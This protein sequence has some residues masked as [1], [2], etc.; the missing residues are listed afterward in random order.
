MSVGKMSFGQFFQPKTWKLLFL[1]LPLI[2]FWQ[3]KLN[4]FVHYFKTK[5]LIVS[6]TVYIL[7]KCKGSWCQRL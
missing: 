7:E 5:N 3:N 1:S 4:I 2:E 6:K